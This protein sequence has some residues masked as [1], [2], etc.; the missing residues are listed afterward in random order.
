MVERINQNFIAV[1][2]FNQLVPDEGPKCISIKADFN[3]VDEYLV[4]LTNQVQQK[5]IAAVQTIYFDNSYQNVKVNIVA[6]TTG[7]VITLPALTQGYI[8]AL[9]NKDVTFSLTC[10]G[11]TGVFLAQ[12]L[13]VPMAPYM[14]AADNR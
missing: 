5:R 8:P 4:E 7:Q 9:I 2:V 13:N 10:T 6:D 12:L 11:G 1:P 3:G 14:W